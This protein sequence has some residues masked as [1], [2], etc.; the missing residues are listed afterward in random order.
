M[1]LRALILLSFFPWPLFSASVIKVSKSGKA[2]LIGKDEERVWQKGEDVCVS[3]DKLILG[4]GKVLKTGKR[5]ALLT[6][7]EPIARGLKPQTE[8]E[9]LARFAP[10]KPAPVIKVEKKKRKKKP[11]EDGE[12]DEIDTATRVPIHGGGSR[13]QFHALFDLLLSYKASGV[14]PALTFSNDHAVITIE[15]SPQANL[16]FL[17]EVSS[18]PRFFEINYALTPSLSIRTGRLWIPFDELGPHTFYGGRANV[19]KLSQSTGGA[20]L[21]DYWSE[22]GVG[23]K[24]KFEMGS[25]IMAEAQV[26]VV[27][28]FQDGGTDP[29][30]AAPSY[31]DFGNTLFIQD[32]NDDKAI[33]GRLHLLIGKSLGIGTSVYRTRYTPKAQPNGSVLMIGTDAQYRVGDSF[34]LRAAYAY[35]SVTLP[36]ESS[37]RRGGIYGELGYSFSPWKLLV[38]AGQSQNDSRIESVSD[39]LI[40][41][42]ALLYRAKWVQL[43]LEHSQD[44][45][46]VAGK[47]YKSFTGLRMMTRF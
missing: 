17:A 16:G 12:E 1:Q 18:N 27:N 8:L 33:G 45:H 5:G 14:D 38:R 41:G 29:L 6:F 13:P 32:N 2:I 47:T 39:Q 26:Y 15:Y 40:V 35:M 43:S 10:P 22:L 37:F 3:V 7:K 25:D 46:E 23:L 42:A 31:P 44:I 19:V 34:E 30:G 36:D 24:S 11:K 20:F 9:L 4:C 28:G 21:P